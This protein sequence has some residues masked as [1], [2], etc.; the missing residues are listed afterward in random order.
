MK[1]LLS[2]SAHLPQSVKL[3]AVLV[4]AAACLITFCFPAVAANWSLDQLMS[5]LAQNKTAKAKFSEIK[6]LA[7][8]ETPVESSG[9]LLYV[10]PNKLVKRT[11]KP[12]PEVMQLDG[13]TLTLER[14]KN[15][16]TMQVQEAP[17]LAALIES[18]RGTLAGDRAALERNFSVAMTGNRER[19]TLSMKPINT[20]ALQVIRNIEVSG[21]KGE[22]QEIEVLQ[23]NGDRS[24]TSV[25][26]RP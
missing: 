25:E 13:D 26:K 24:I 2:P 19:W 21:S 15:K 23:A 1:N 3:H 12:R 8:L 9:E 22:I 10:A 6:Y 4:I 7:V 5:S 14:G 17:E 18:M 11:I 16:F 20:K